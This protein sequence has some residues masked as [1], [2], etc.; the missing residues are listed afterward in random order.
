MTL[1]HFQGIGVDPA[2]LRHRFGGRSVGVTEMLRCA[3]D[4]GLKARVINTCW[5]RL[6]ATPLPG[7]AVRR[8]YRVDRATWLLTEGDLCR[9]SL[10]EPW[11]AAERQAGDAESS[12]PNRVKDSVNQPRPRMTSARPF[13]AAFNVENL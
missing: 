12:Q 10:R 2:Q 6:A 9:E 3:K 4:L 13:D 7:I 11:P 5:R 8:E 1:L